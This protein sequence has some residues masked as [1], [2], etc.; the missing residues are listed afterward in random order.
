MW[1][2]RN[3]QRR[4]CLLMFRQVPHPRKVRWR[5]KVQVYSYPGETRTQDERKLRIRRS[6][7]VSSA[8][9]RCI[10]WRVTGHSHGETCRYK[11]GIRDVYLSESETASEEDVTGKPVAC[12]QLREKP[13]APSQQACQGRPKAEK[14]EWSHNLRVS[15]ATLH[16]L[17]TVFS[18]VRRSTDENTMTLWMIWMWIWLF[19]AYF[20]MPL[21]EQ[22]FILDKIMRWIYDAWRIIFGTVQDSYS[23]KLENWSVIKWNHWFYDYWIYWKPRGCRQA[24]CANKLIG[25]SPTPKPTSSPTLCS[26]CE[27]WEMILLRTGRVKFQW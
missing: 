22:Q 21:F 18:I 20:W 13:C 24:Y 11:R 27:K 9:E 7:E 14:T 25:G 15:P 4:T 10:P 2:N 17:G 16:H 6:V 3:L 26:A 23:A 5:P 8:T 12:E 19:G 1:H